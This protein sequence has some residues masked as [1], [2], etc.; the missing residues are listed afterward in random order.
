MGILLILI[1]LIAYGLVQ[2]NR[3]LPPTP[4]PKP[5]GYDDFVKAGQTLVGDPGNYD[6]MTQE[7]LRSLIATNVE[8]LKLIRQGLA[9]HSRIALDFSTNYLSVRM[10]EFMTAKKLACLLVADGRWAEFKH[11]TND[12]AKIYMQ[13]I[14]FSNEAVRGGVM[15]DRLLGSACEAIGVGSLQK[16]VNDLDV[17]NCR[18]MIQS[19]QETRRNREPLMDVLLHEREWMRRNSTLR[20]RL[21]SLIPIPAFNPT[22][23]MKQGFLSTVQ[24]REYKLDQLMLELAT[25]AYELENGKLPKSPA[26]LVPEYLEAMP[27]APTNATNDSGFIWLLIH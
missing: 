23:R 12:A 8:V 16:L 6:T 14:R 22:K 4:L 7:E 20:E 15:I 26:D 21:Q 1:A 25:R 9:R 2:L 11:L 10:P 13:T 19:L 17:Q 27:T 18:A 5:N 3:A 24:S